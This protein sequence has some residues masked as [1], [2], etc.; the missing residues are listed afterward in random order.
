M[1]LF[2]ILYSFKPMLVTLK[3]FQGNRSLKIKG[4]F[5]LFCFVF[6]VSGLAFNLLIVSRGQ[7][8]FSSERLLFLFCQ[9]VHLKGSLNPRTIWLSFSGPVVDKQT[10]SPTTHQQATEKK[11]GK[12]IANKPLSSHHPDDLIVDAVVSLKDLKVKQCD[13]SVFWCL[14]DWLLGRLVVGLV[15]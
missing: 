8:V 15:G 4:L 11:E 9:P 13:R 10:P 3:Y 7:S 2:V 14:W 5:V 6:N 1:V 12:N